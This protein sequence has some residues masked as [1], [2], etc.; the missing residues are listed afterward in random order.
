M[1]LDLYLTHFDVGIG[2]D[3]EEVYVGSDGIF[4]L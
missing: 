4:D 1:G 3:I 2:E